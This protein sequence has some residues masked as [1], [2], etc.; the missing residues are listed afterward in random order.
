M[1][2]VYPVKSPKP[3]SCR[4]Q[5]TPFK[6]WKLTVEVSGKVRVEG[7]GMGTAVVAVANK[8]AKRVASWKRILAKECK[9]PRVQLESNWSWEL[10][11][12]DGLKSNPK[13]VVWRCDDTYNFISGAVDNAGSPQP[14]FV[15]SNPGLQFLILD[16]LIQSHR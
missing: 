13:R 16:A 10:K 1:R 8:V 12:V 2:S 14:L 5:S 7:S 4:T 3:V 9:D 15:I 6:V 11:R